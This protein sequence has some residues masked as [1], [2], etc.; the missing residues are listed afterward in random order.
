MGF[1]DL[2]DMSSGKNR[3]SRI[4]ANNLFVEHKNV[5]TV[6]DLA[7]DDGRRDVGEENGVT[8]SQ[9]HIRNF[10]MHDYSDL[11]NTDPSKG[12][13]KT[14][15]H[16]IPTLN[17]QIIPTTHWEAFTLEFLKHQECRG[18]QMFE[19]YIGPDAAKGLT[20]PLAK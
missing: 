14:R 11:A 4:D 1:V 17:F 12:V 2:P 13:P 8:C 20:C 3:P 15:N 16:K 7:L 9:C 19:Q 18:K 5:F 6:K 10:G